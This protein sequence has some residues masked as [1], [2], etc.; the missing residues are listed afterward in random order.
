[1]AVKRK[2]PRQRNSINKE[3]I[4]SN[5]ETQLNRDLEALASLL[6]DLYCSRPG[7]RERGSLD[8]DVPEADR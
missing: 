5:T 8:I 1:M 6:L 4:V 2:S 3:L 7:A